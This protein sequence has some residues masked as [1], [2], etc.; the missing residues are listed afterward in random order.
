[1]LLE[2]SQEVYE[3]KQVDSAKQYYCWVASVEL[4]SAEIFHPYNI[5]EEVDKL[6]K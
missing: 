5:R 1:M 4:H 2:V 6:D 3:E